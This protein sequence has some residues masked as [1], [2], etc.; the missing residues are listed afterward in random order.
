MELILI[1]HGLPERRDDT[2][3]PPLSEVGHEQARRVAAWLRDE[4]IHAV[5]SSTMLRARQTAEPFAGHAGHAVICHDGIC[6]FDRDSGAYVPMEELKRDDYEAWLRMAT[7]DHGVDIGGFQRA[8]VETLEKIVEDHAGQRV[9]VFCH[10][11]VI[12]V[13]TAH[14]LGMAPRLF[15][16][17]DY[18]SVHRYMCARTGQR[19]VVA[20]NERA[21][22]R[23]PAA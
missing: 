7:G 14:V 23:G 12:N 19:N 9:A 17:P 2:A 3:D 18:T 1:R 13:W 5:Y 8:V 4:P 22:L 20:L 16:E 15:F 11:G 21:H 6:E 10:G